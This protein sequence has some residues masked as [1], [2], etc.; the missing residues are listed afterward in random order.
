MIVWIASYPRSG[1]RYF[2]ELLQ[3][4]YDLKSYSVYV[5]PNRD[6]KSGGKSTAKLMSS[7]MTLVDMAK[8]KETYFVKTH[9]FPQDDFP[10]IYL[11]RD[12]RDSVVS[13]AHFILTHEKETHNC[14][15][16]DILKQVIINKAYFGGW[17]NH[18]TAWTRR[19][20]P[21]AII[22]FENLVQSE[23]PLSI[24]QEALN[25][26]GYSQYTHLRNTLPPTFAELHATHP[27][28]YR[29]GKI[30]NWKIEMPLELQNLFQAEYGKV[31]AE[32]GYMELEINFL[33]KLKLLTVKEMEEFRE[34]IKNSFA[35]PIPYRYGLIT[36]YLIKKIIK[37]ILPFKVFYVLRLI[38]AKVT[39]S[40]APK[41]FLPYQHLPIPL[42]IPEN[43]YKS[44]V[45]PQT[46]LPVVSIVTP[47]FNHGK[48]LD[49]T[50]KSVL[51]QNYP[52]LEY[53]VQDGG[54]TDASTEIL[55]KYRSQITSIE[56][57]TD[58]GQSHALNLGFNRSTGEIMAYLN[59]DDLLLPG[60]IA[61][62]VNFFHKNPQ[63]DVVYGHRI[64]I[65]TNDNEVGR[66]VLPPYN[67]KVI[68][69]ADYI[70]QET[71]FWRRRIWD[72]VGGYIDESYQY[73]MDW[74]L[75]LRFRQAG[76]KFERLP[77]FLGAFRFHSKQKTFAMEHIGIE[78]TNRLREQ[79]LGTVKTQA[80][81]D[82]NIR[83][84]LKLADCFDRLYR[85]GV[86]RY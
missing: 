72:K 44:T 70:P 57:A 58:R 37:G 47:S 84:Y 23:N 10:A 38:Y 7:H 75:L 52:Q 56:S 25:A 39:F 54:S 24:L 40:T 2:R 31:M 28:L 22:K 65:D 17:G 85:K 59:S 69:W 3:H 9:E 41:L 12:G 6:L 49:R 1:N 19:K 18:V 8:A 61:Y 53:I 79:Y 64:I 48:F 5:E 60:T 45:S 13:Y 66:W 14:D 30:N 11:L 20:A 35:D 81:V 80:E 4:F 51:E 76:A 21:T 67:E 29:K 42:K 83:F 86:L 55:E 16:K 68:A 63:I 33:Q 50:I 78:E 77:R 46:S 73:A 62:V 82:E 32:H 71:L 34:V 43:Y 26:L 36:R 74:E 15:F 27:T